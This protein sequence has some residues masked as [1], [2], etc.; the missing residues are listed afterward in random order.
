[1]RDS[2]ATGLEL[3]AAITFSTILNTPVL[4]ARTIRRT[5]LQRHGRLV[6]EEPS[7][8]RPYTGSFGLATIVAVGSN[9]GLDSGRDLRSSRR[10]RGLRA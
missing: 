6:E 7:S 9:S 2:D 4:E 1:M 10:S 8:Q 5:H 3:I